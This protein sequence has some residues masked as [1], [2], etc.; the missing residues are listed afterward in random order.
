MQALADGWRAK[1][2]SVG[3]VPTMGALH[4]GHLSLL[5]R[6]RRENKVL[7][8]SVFVNP[9]QFGPKEDLSRYPRPFK[10]DAALC[11]AAG[12]DVLFHPSPGGLY[13]PGF[14]AWVDVP[15]LSA[16]LC[17]PFRPGHFRGVATVVA[18][19][20]NLARPTRAY[21][22]M[23]DFQQLAV[24]KRMAKDL[25]LP[26]RV[27]PCPT[28]READGLAMS[29]RNAYLSPAE[30]AAAARVPAALRAAAQVLNRVPAL[31]SRERGARRGRNWR[32]SPARGS[33]TWTWW[34]R[35]RWRRWSVRPV[36]PS[37]PWRSS[38]E[39]RAS[40]TTS[41]SDK[42]FHALLLRRPLAAVPGPRDGHPAGGDPALS[43]P[44]AH[45]G[46]AGGAG[47][48]GAGAPRAAHL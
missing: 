41:S 18:K 9:T 7:V 22:G 2:L 13:P 23:K 32:R 16:T 24:I 43:G 31:P 12:V 28:V 45:P 27:V 30:R 11:R 39:R 15:A 3:F 14:G 4:A 46:H 25:D 26:V 17:G 10:K 5:R 36:R 8:A 19:L 47:A 34:T 29:S 1:R 21:F 35:R 38:W 6:A 33:N 48:A 20:F 37:R 40:S 42:E 44:E